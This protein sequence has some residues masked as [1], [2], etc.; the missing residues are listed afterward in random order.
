MQKVITE[1]RSVLCYSADRE[2]GVEGAQMARRLKMSQQ[3]VSYAVRKGERTF[4]EASIP[5]KG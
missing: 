2:F 4:K 1:E 5:L 3:R